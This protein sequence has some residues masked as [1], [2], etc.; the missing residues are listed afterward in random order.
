MTLFN[1]GKTNPELF[2]DLE[3]LRGDRK[4]DLEALKGRR[5]DAVIDTSG[6]VP[7]HVKMSAQLLA[8]S[9]D[10]YVFVST[11]SVYADFENPYM[12]EDYPVGKLEDET[13]EKVDME[14]YGPLKAL[15]EQAA[16][17]A[18]PGRV[19]NVRPGLIVGPLDRSDRFTYWPARVARGGEVLA[20]GDGTDFTQ[21]IDVRDVAEFLVMC[22]ERRIAGVYNV[23]SPPDS[24]TMRQ[25]LETCRTVIPTD[26]TFTWVPTDFLDEHEVAPWSEMP[27]WLPVAVEPSIGRI[28]TARARR[29]GLGRRPIEETIR[30]TLDW[31]QREPAERHENMR[32]GM[33]PERESEVLAAWHARQGG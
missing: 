14:T 7:R 4:D 5:W 32:S 18:M 26:A 33:K 22:I 9:V 27:C 12:D 21:F 1:R 24:L 17:A 16:E 28:S 11:V 31:W 19:A 13:V 2:P 15:C 3:K 10:F 6:Y 23:D 8:P 20:P 30:D 25:L 29:A